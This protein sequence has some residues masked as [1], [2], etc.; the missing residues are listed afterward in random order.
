VLSPPLAITGFG[1]AS[2]LGGAATACS[3]ARAGL[4]RPR[5]LAYGVG[6]PESMDLVPVSGHP[7]AE[8]TLGFAEAG[9]MVRLATLAL[10]D[11]FER[12]PLTQDEI[13]QAAVLINL[14]SGFYFEQVDEERA[15]ADQREGRS[16][17]TPEA[18]ETESLAEAFEV[19]KPLYADLV[20]KSF[21]FLGSQAPPRERQQVV[22][23]D[24][25]GIAPLVETAHRLIASRTVSA[26]LI[27]GVDSLLEP[28]W[29]R[30]CEALGILKT[31]I[32]PVGLMPGEGAAF[33]L[34]ESGAVSGKRPA[35][36]QVTACASGRESVHRFS[37]SRSEGRVLADVIRRC[38]G[39]GG[40][41]A[42]LIS[43]VNGDP[44]RAAELGTALLRL[45]GEFAPYAMIA[46]A[47]AFGDTRAASAFLGVCSALHAVKRGYAPTPRFV[48]TASGDDPARAALLVHAPS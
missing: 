16:P 22:F 35:L 30:C 12:T 25:A 37:D 27:G 36:G 15:R 28:R 21:R 39:P 32:H 6:D 31:P 18:G 1:M 14:P 17:K 23:G 5:P 47:I 9:L 41:D 24:P 29:L 33:L 48:V 8:L 4:S 40:C 34:V 44:V 7:V 26:C 13:R 42:S 45:T 43:D 38:V 10:A 3:A 20:D 11:L 2:S 46:P 19:T